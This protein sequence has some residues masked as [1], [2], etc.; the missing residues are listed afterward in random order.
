MTKWKKKLS[1]KPYQSQTH[2][3][4]LFHCF[5]S[6]PRHIF[7]DYIIETKALAESFVFFKGQPNPTWTKVNKFPN[8]TPNFSTQK[9]IL[10]RITHSQATLG[11][12][13]GVA[14]TNFLILHNFYSPAVTNSGRELKNLCYNHI[15]RIRFDTRLKFLSAWRTQEKKKEEGKKEYEN[16][17]RQRSSTRG[18]ERSV[19]YAH[20]NFVLRGTR[21]WRNKKVCKDLKRS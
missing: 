3:P 18:R 16:A 14:E 13:C 11:R 2:K 9:P 6:P 12:F 20:S 8:G 15:W 19:R 1:V 5:E 10:I 17:C 21:S 4:A 7:F